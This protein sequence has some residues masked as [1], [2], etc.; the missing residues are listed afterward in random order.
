M[1]KGQLSQIAARAA[2]SLDVRR[3]P[4]RRSRAPADLAAACDNAA[5]ELPNPLVVNEFLLQAQQLMFYLS[6]VARTDG[7]NLRRSWRSPLS[8]LFSKSPCPKRHHV[9]C[10]VGVLAHRL[11]RGPWWATTPTQLKSHSPR[12]GLSH[13]LGGGK[14]GDLRGA[15]RLG[16]EKTL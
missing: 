5:N 12:S 16:K 1:R 8:A 3:A 2:Q 15:C 11:H 14:R 9:F 13:P 6:D 4:S 7:R 10:R